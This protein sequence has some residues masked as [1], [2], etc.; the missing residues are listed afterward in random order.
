MLI[1]LVVFFCS[2]LWVCTALAAPA[3]DGLSSLQDCNRPLIPVDE[4][5]DKKWNFNAANVSL[6]YGIFA[7]ASADSY[8]KRVE[9]LKYIPEGSLN[10]FGWERLEWQPRTTAYRYSNR[11]TGLSFDTYHKEI[12]DCVFVILA[13]RGTNF[14]SASDWYSNFSWLT[15]ALPLP[16]QY[17]DISARFR[18]IKNFSKIKFGKKPIKYITTGHSLG[19]GLA[20]HIAKCFDEV[21]AIV[22]NTSFVHNAI[23]CKKRDNVIIEIYDEE[24]VLSA[25]RVLAGR[26]RQK[27]VNDDKLSTYGINPVESENRAPIDQH[28]ITKM[29][30]GMLRMP[31]ECLSDKYQCAMSKRLMKTKLVE[32]RAI[33][34]DNFDV[35]T[36]HIYDFKEVCWPS[37]AAGLRRK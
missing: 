16:N 15:S 7:A 23:F 18:E 11:L 9:D 19:G 12:D 35:N 1:R 17:R 37:K 32:T 36:N 5:L 26:S 8:E 29:A 3:N 2:I 30:L 4:H 6:A 21:S 10:E 13:I 33:L 28:S 27:H 20:I 31:L 22:F 14:E 34:C 24:E 25:V